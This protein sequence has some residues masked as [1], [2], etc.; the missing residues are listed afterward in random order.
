MN[1]PPAPALPVLSTGATHPPLLLQP[2]GGGE[3]GAAPIGRVPSSG[4]HPLDM[5]GSVFWE[6]EVRWLI[7]WK[8]DDTPLKRHVLAPQ[9]RRAEARRGDA[10][11]SSENIK[12]SAFGIL[13][14]GERWG[15]AHLESLFICSGRE[16]PARQSGFSKAPENCIL[17]QQNAEAE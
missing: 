7:E 9:A 16:L 12:I 13:H 5:P 8:R 17:Q 10:G 1:P 14:N 3:A 15:A 4:G 6:G 11:A 2:E